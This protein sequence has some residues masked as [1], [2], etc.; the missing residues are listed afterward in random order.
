MNKSL[1]NL[2][3]R[4]VI[5]FATS[6]ANQPHVI[7]VACAKVVNSMI[8]ITDNF[9]KKTKLNIIKNKSVALAFWKGDD[10]YKISG[11]A[12][13]HNKGKWLDFVKKI[14]EN[15]GLPAKG[16]I[17]IKINKISK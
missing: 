13:Y 17:I 5:A 11:K 12:T 8:I 15:N 7:P 10:C 2:I 14:K 6:S 3:E 4:S 16:A 9:M 1:K